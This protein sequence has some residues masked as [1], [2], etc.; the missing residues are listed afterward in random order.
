MG[1]L[2]N[3]VVQR[4]IV[5]V[6]VSANQPMRLRDIHAG[7]ENMLGHPVSKESVAW[8]VR[9]SKSGAGPRFQRVAYGRYR[10][11]SQT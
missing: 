9:T 2:G 3:G 11:M 5:K 10:L 4:A 8:C 6:L 1:R 7:V